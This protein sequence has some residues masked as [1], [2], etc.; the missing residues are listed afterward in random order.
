[1][2]VP[3]LQIRSVGSHVRKG[4]GMREANEAVGVTESSSPEQVPRLLIRISDSHVR[5]KLLYDKIKSP[6]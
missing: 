6:L 2:G 4:E 1:M 5:I 3:Q